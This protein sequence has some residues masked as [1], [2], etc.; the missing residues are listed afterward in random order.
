MTQVSPHWSDADWD[1]LTLGSTLLPG[2]WTLEGSAERRIDV[3]PRKGQDGATL[4]DEG[5]QNAQ[6]TLTGRLVN[7]EDHVALQKSLQEIHPRRKGSVRDPLAIVHPAVTALGISSVY[8]TSIALPQL[9]NGV[10][11]QVIEV[12]EY[13]PQPKP[14]PKKRPWSPPPLGAGL[15]DVRRQMRGMAYTGPS[16]LEHIHT[17][18]DPPSEDTDWTAM[19]NERENAAIFAE[20]EDELGL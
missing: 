15:G 4:K 13:T 5:Y 11:T 6:V 17:G 2:I 10:L 19:Q 14:V 20:L 16:G 7:K 8:V 18:Y 12:L 9:E 1:Q 3:K